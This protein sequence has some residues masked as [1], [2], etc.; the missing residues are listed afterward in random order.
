MNMKR[1]F[2]T[3]C[4]VLAQC[5]ASHATPFDIDYSR[6]HIYV[7]PFYNW[8]GPVVSV[9]RFS[10]GLASENEDEFLA[11]IATMKEEWLT[12]SF[13]QLY[14]AAI[15]LYDRGFRKE[16]VYWFYTAQYRGR[17]FGTLL[18]EAKMGSIGSDGFELLHAQNAF[19]QLSGPWING[20]AFGD[21]DELVKVVER[22]QR[23]ARQIPDME[24]L[25]P[26]VTFKEKRVWIAENDALADR[27][28]DLVTMLKDQKE[29]IRR[30]RIESGMDKT[31]SELTNK[32][33][34]SH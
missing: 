6:I 1:L 30:Q 22:V 33:L 13:A 32:E 21:L 31:F 9:G 2:L 8:D 26:G 20:Y 24:S 14:V 29:E 16:S 12:L 34:K 27:M 15:R 10:A 18:D 4:A 25:Y 19:F 28:S 7:T 17:Q 23:E 5:T 3:V 11:T